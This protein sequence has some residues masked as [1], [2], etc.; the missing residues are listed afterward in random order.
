[1]RKL[2]KDGGSRPAIEI[3]HSLALFAK[4]QLISD[5]Q[6]SGTRCRIPWNEI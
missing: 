4:V 6:F 3:V 5:G 1:M 2:L